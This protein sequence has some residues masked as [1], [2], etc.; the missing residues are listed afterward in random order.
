MKTEYENMCIVIVGIIIAN[1]F[2]ITHWNVDG[3]LGY[4]IMVVAMC[5]SYVF[6]QFDTLEYKLLGREIRRIRREYERL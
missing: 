5:I 6:F 4:L 3:F 2:L 1:S